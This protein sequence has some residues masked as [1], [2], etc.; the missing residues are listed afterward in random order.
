ML[1]IN[2]AVTETDQLAH[3]QPNAVAQA[4]A[5]G[6]SRSTEKAWLPWA[7]SVEADPETWD[8]RV[9]QA[10]SAAELE[11][12]AGGCSRAAAPPDVFTHIYH[13][14]VDALAPDGCKCCFFL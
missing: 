14:V 12:T 7:I 8:V 13:G 5:D 11:S 1:A 6:S 2:C 10:G 9:Q 4:L 3:W